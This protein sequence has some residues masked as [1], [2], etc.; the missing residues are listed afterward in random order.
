MLPQLIRCPRASVFLSGAVKWIAGLFIAIVPRLA[1][2]YRPFDGT[3]G[4]TAEL[5]T[6]ELEIGP[7]QGSLG[8]GSTTYEPGFVFNYGFSTGYELVVDVDGVLPVGS[9]R[10]QPGHSDVASGTSAVISDVLVKHLVRAGVLQD[11]SGP[12]IAIETGV[13]LPNLPVD[14]PDNAGW[15]FALIGSERLGPV[16]VHLNL[17]TQ[18]NPNRTVSAFASTIL[19]GPEDWRVR[20]VLEALVARDGDSGRELS[21]LAGAIWRWRKSVSFD[22]AGRVQRELGITTYELRGGLTWVFDT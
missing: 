14:A 5:N 4:D 20:P 12:S 10:A 15:S 16:T 18:Y 2:A 7:L 8:Q 6:I 3:D 13:L 9:A 21:L 22:G 1:L 11:L 19:E 17:E